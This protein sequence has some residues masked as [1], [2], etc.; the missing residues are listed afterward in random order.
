LLDRHGRRETG[1]EINVRTLHLLDELPRIGRHAVEEAP[2]PL[3]EENVEGQ[4]RFPRS[5]EPGEDDELFPRNR[6]GKVL[7][8]VLA[9]A[10]ERNRVCLMHRAVKHGR[11]G[12]FQ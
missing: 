4:G 9:G 8:V 12:D 1:D 11:F 2:L 3:G 5:A 7:E 10:V 6:K